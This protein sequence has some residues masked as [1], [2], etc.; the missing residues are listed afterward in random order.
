[1]LHSLKQ[2]KP[3]LPNLELYVIDDGLYHPDLG[4]L[5]DNR[6]LEDFLQ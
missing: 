3:L 2:I 1:L 5:I 6:P 4:L